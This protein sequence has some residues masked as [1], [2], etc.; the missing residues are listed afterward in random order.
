MENKLLNI[1]ILGA[2]PNNWCDSLLTGPERVGDLPYDSPQVEK[3]LD[4]VRKRIKAILYSQ[5]SDPAECQR[6]ELCSPTTVR[7]DE[8]CPHYPMA[9]KDLSDTSEFKEEWDDKY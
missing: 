6:A 2:I 3:L 7:C 4:G 8:D 9:I 5:P 1:E